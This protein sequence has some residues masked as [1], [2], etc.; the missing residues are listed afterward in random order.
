MKKII[1]LLFLCASTFALA[2]CGAVD[3]ST[4]ETPSPSVATGYT[5]QFNTHGGTTVSTITN[6]SYI[7]TSPV[8]TKTNYTFSA[9]N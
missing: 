5:V 6:V 9:C 1:S 3:P 7:E 2:G 4:P 8:T